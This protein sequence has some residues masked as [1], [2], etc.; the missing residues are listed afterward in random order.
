MFSP[1]FS[2]LFLHNIREKYKCFENFWGMG[3][4]LELMAYFFATIMLYEELFNFLIF[5]KLGLGN[6]IY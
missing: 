1:F 6:L 5:N 4:W 2:F 3:D